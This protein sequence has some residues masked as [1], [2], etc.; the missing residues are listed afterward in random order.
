MRSEILTAMKISIWWYRLHNPRRKNLKWDPEL[1]LHRGSAP[2][3][4]ATLVPDLP[5]GAFNVCK[6]WSVSQSLQLFNIVTWLCPPSYGSSWG[7]G[8]PTSSCCWPTTVFP[9]D[10]TTPGIIFYHFSLN[11]SNTNILYTVLRERNRAFSS[12]MVVVTSLKTKR[13]LLNPVVVLWS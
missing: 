13:V 6:Q 4:R 3:N 12:H 1:A 5:V 9:L 10:L 8:G 11:S 7:A 2:R